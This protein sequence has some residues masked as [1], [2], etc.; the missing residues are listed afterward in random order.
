MLE[1]HHFSL[2]PLYF[3]ALGLLHIE[4]LIKLPIQKGSFDV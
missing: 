4:L 1:M 2:L 3:E